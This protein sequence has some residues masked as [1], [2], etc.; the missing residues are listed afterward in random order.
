MEVGVVGGGMESP[1]GECKLSGEVLTDDSAR[2]SRYDRVA[3]VTPGSE[4][5]YYTFTALAQ[6]KAGNKSEQIVRTTVNDD[7]APVVGLIVG[8]YSKGAWSL[9]GTL[10]D[11]PLASRRTGP[12]LFHRRSLASRAS[13]PIRR[14]RRQPPCPDSAA[15]RWSWR[16]TSTT[17]RPDAEHTWSTPPIT[18]QV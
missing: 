9:T 18:M 3:W 8:G 5:G 12:R 11:G 7:A 4:T 6:D 13:T 1:A 2:S 17:R 16:S 10:T 14:R 15:G